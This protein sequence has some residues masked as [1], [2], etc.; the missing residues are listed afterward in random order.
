MLRTKSS[1]YLPA[2]PPSLP[3][4]RPQRRF[5]DRRDRRWKLDCCDYSCTP[6]YCNCNSPQNIH[7]DSERLMLHSP[8]SSGKH[9]APEGEIISYIDLFTALF[10]SKFLEQLDDRRMAETE[11]RENLGTT[12][13]T[14]GHASLENYGEETEM[15]RTY[16]GESSTSSASCIALLLLS[17]ECSSTRSFHESER[18][19]TSQEVQAETFTSPLNSLHPES[20]QSQP[21]EDLDGRNVNRRENR[22]GV[23]K[24]SRKKYL[25]QVSQCCLHNLCNKS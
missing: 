12:R 7:A 19:S 10:L 24:I 13:V 18:T 3:Y 20:L 11:S 17:S 16:D 9:P 6:W 23:S 1:L 2:T 15:V 22:G 8:P 14:S 4:P 5:F 21:S 25:K